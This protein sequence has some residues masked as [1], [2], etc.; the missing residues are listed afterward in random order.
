MSEQGARAHNFLQISL[1][2]LEASKE[3][4][5]VCWL[6][7]NYS[8]LQTGAQSGQGQDQDNGACSRK[9]LPFCFSI[10]LQNVSHSEHKTIISTLVSCVIREESISSWE[11]TCIVGT[12][13]L[14]FSSGPCARGSSLAFPV[15]QQLTAPGISGQEV[16]MNKT[17]WQ[18]ESKRNECVSSSFSGIPC[19]NVYIL[20]TGLKSS[21]HLYQKCDMQ[22]FSTFTQID[23][24]FT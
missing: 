15:I 21:A 1:P 12:W 2:C 22:N 19:V 10:A 13:N 6:E 23:L 18:A 4:K 17:A 8:M 14:S 9:H 7:G 24:C 11:I 20:I 3:R 5:W 16:W